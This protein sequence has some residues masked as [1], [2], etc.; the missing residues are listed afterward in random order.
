M[1]NKNETL[2]LIKNN[3]SNIEDWVSHG[4]TD[5]NIA[6]KLGIAYSTLRKYK[7]EFAELKGAISKGKDKANE[8]VEEALY[9]NAIGFYY[10]EEVANKVKD[11]EV[12]DGQIVV[13]ERI[14]IVKVKKYS[15]PDLAA[16]KFWLVN[17]KNTAWKNDPNVV[18]NNNKMAKLKEKEVENKML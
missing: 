14:E 3:L 5:K 17:R 2:E 8:N 12:V 18:A 9:N 10:T 13:H 7:K 11:E 15:K 4:A 6:E 16:Q 1:I